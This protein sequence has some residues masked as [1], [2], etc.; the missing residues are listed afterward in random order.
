MNFKKPKFWDLKKISILS[1]IL[2]PLSFLYQLINLVTKIFRSLKKFPIPVICVGNIYLGGTGK[3][4]LARE[5]YNIV[6][7][8]NKKPAFIKK[9]YPYLKM[10]LKC[11]KKLARYL[12]PKIEHLAYLS[13]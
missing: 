5:I 6:K 13:L 1:I 7:S 12:Y 4:P 8:L 2:L 3:T 11:W 9:P 10:K